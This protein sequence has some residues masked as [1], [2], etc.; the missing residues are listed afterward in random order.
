M[1]HFAEL[2]LNNKVINVTFVDNEHILDLEGNENE[3]VGIAFL[4]QIKPSYWVQTSYNGNTRGKFAGIG[5]T[6]D[7]NNFVAPEP[8]ESTNN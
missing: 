1:A 2:N 6:W 4:N 8:E 3:T 7:G 5:D